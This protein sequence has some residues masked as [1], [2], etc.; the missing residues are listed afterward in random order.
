MS[1]QL[2]LKQHKF[3]LHKPTFTWIIKINTVQNC[4]CIFSIFIVK[5]QYTIHVTYKICINQLF[6]L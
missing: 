4:K 2:T 1:I 3:E 5:I 6:V